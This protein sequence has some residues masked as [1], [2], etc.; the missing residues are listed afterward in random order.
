MLTPSGRF[1]PGAKICLSM[2]DFHP[3]SWNPSWG[4]R[5]ILL[6][7]QSFFYEES[8]TTGA[9]Q[10]VSAA[11]RK[12]HAKESLAYNINNPT[13]RKLF[14][15]LVQLHEDKRLEE[16]QQ[17]QRQQE[18]E[19][20]RTS[21]A[22]GGLGTRPGGGIG[23]YERRERYGPQESLWTTAIISLLIAV[24]AGVIAVAFATRGGG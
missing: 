4:V 8:S 16:Q 15:E 21:A 18:Q 20:Q 12:K 22:E 9:L 19:R 5:L 13:Y 17:Q 11:E 1:Q 24:A 6:G 14:P 23:E 7:I 3:E 10:G 2:S